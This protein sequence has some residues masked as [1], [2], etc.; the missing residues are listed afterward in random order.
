MSVEDDVE[1]LRQIPI[2]S[3]IA[4]GKL[5]LMAFAA[6][7]VTFQKGHELF[8][9]GEPGDVAYV[10]LQGNTDVIIDTPSGPYKVV[11]DQYNPIVGEIAM[12]IDVPRTATVIA[13]EDLVCLKLTKPLFF[14]LVAELPK[15]AVEII[16]VLAQHAQHTAIARGEPIEELGQGQEAPA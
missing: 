3:E 5:K 11:E 1:V 14:E 9:Q 2:F 15:V 6:E 8:R 7:R 13:T 12:L 4:V 16:R 10:V